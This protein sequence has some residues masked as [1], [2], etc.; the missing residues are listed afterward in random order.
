MNASSVFF[1]CPSWAGLLRFLISEK[2]FEVAG[3]GWVSHDE[4][5]SSVLGIINQLTVGRRALLASG[6]L[7]PA[8]P[9][10]P[11]SSQAATANVPS[12]RGVLV[13]PSLV[14]WQ[15]DSFGHSATTAKLFHAFHYKA[16]FAN[17]IHRLKK[18]R[19]RRERSLEFEWDFERSCEDVVSGGPSLFSN[20]PVSPTSE[21]LLTVILDN[22]YA[23]PVDFENARVTK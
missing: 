17:R 11:S 14:S 1:T 2:Q 16:H 12:P 18:A 4:A 15:L 8:S 19:M 9:T 10:A 20:I 5:L 6:V 7:A 21:R 22:H 13:T 3:G 23:A